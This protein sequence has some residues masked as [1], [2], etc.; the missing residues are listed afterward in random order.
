MKILCGSKTMKAA[1][2]LEAGKMPIYGDFKEP[3]PANGKVQITVSAAALSNVVKSRASGAHYSSS[4]QLP[5]VVGIDG[6][7]RLDDGR[8]VYFALPRAPFGSMSQKTVIPPSQCVFLPDDLDDVTAAAIAN[9][10]MSAW[11]A[12]KERAKLTV[13]ETVLINGAT[14][15]AGR[16]A[17]QIAKYMGAR[18][19]V[20]TGRNPEALNGLSAF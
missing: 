10:G 5:F 9:P 3:V 14:G 11:A 17:V 8:R 13:G 7:G 12:F 1:I 19:V 20:A 4:G 6:V 2:V 15:T 16:L 18:K